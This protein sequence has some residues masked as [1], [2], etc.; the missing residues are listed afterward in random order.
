MSESANLSGLGTLGATQWQAQWQ[1][2]QAGRLEGQLKAAAGAVEK[3]K[4]QSQAKGP[5]DVSAADRAAQTKRLEKVT[6][7]FES[8]F[9]A[10]MLKTMRQAVPKSDFLGQ[11]QAHEI[12]TEMRDEEL[13][14]G[15]AQAGVIGLSRLMVD[16]LKRQL[17]K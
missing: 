9:L 3:A 6:Q 16:Q 14:K 8:I 10:Y 7:D 1:A 5:N 2:A 15:M 17:G 12:F 4:S 11:S 13:A